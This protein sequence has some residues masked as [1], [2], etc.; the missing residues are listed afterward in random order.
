MQLP[1]EQN[2]ALQPRAWTHVR[3]PVRTG[4]QSI[5]RDPRDHARAFLCAH[6]VLVIISSIG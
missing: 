2:A 4:Q 5:V 1:Q 3:R 6:R